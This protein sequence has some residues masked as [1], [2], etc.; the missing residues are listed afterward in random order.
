MSETSPTGFALNEAQQEAVEHTKGPL[1]VVAGAGSG[2]TRVIVEKIQH[3][4]EQ[5]LKPHTIIAITFTNKAANTMRE[6]LM[7]YGL[8][9][10]WVC[11][12]HSMCVRI[13][14]KEAQ[15]LGLS[16]QFSI[17]NDEDQTT[18]IRSILKDM[19]LSEEDWKPK[20]VLSEISMHKNQGITATDL[21][22]EA[23][24]FNEDITARVYDRYEKSLATNQALDFDDLLLKTVQLFQRHES[25]LQSY[26]K[27]FDYLLVD[28]YQDTNSIQYQLV[29][30]L[31]PGT[32]GLTL[33]GDPDQSIY[34]WRGADINNILNFQK[35][36][37]DAKIIKMEN[38]YRSKKHILELANQLIR[39]NTERYP[40]E[41]ITDNPDG[42]IPVL[43]QVQDA[44][45]EAKLMADIIEQK[46]A[47]GRALKDVAIFYRT[48]QQSRSIEEALRL[49]NLPYVLVGGTR[50][51]ERKEIKD[52]IAYLRFI[53]NPS[54]SIS[55]M[56]IVNLPARGIGEALKTKIREFADDNGFHC[57]QGMIHKDF[58]E[59]LPP[60]SRKAVENFNALMAGLFEM[61][62]SKPDLLVDQLIRDTEFERSFQNRAGEVDEERLENVQEF[63]SFVVDQSAKNPE[64]TLGT[65]LEEIS[66]MGDKQEGKEG[67][68]EVT[69]FITLMTLHASKGL[70]FPL[71]LFA[72]L[73]EGLLPHQ[74]S[75]DEGN[76][77]LIEE[78]RR[79]TYVGIT[80]AEEELH[81]FTARQRPTFKGPRPSKVSRFISEMQGSHLAISKN[82]TLLH[83][84]EWTE[85]IGSIFRRT[86]ERELRKGSL[87]Q[88]SKFGKGVVMKL[89]G[90][91][92]RQKA[93]VYFDR[94]GEKTVLLEFERLEML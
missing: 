45:R 38:N 16:E 39:H 94:H 51:F 12:F 6:R 18:V 17:F 10:P 25:V 40:K 92:V 42:P 76:P 72:G 23:D 34:S 63:Q 50:F 3:L 33:T 58:L 91:G 70:E 46:R 81:L 88:H 68:E 55:L 86:S 37:D 54:D 71:V 65:L 32:Q 13:L 47:E 87:V 80:R 89:D 67:E 57:W 52:L 48:N 77:S 27:R 60:R 93:T 59:A 83:P 4:V 1:L 20:A 19:E 14:K 85:P 8:E 44:D 9:G 31:A 74:R 53:Y 69:D 29:Q 90:K 24:G 66:L 36:F 22:R 43:H 30:F 49:R 75:I 15:H 56:R 84:R 5:G 21:L 73:D 28:E 35:D 41:A 79:L 2:K 78:E 61:A 64:S 82:G 62:F 11:T 26:R 7:E